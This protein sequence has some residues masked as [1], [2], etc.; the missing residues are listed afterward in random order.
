MVNVLS[1]LSVLAFS[2]S[3]VNAGA[4]EHAHA[5]RHHARGDAVMRR[6]PFGKD[7]SSNLT[8]FEIR[9]KRGTGLNARRCNAPDTTTTTTTSTSSTSTSTS[10]ST[11]PV[12]DNKQKLKHQNDQ[13]YQAP[14]T[15]TTTTPDNT[16][17]TT[18]QPKPTTSSGG[19]GGGGGGGSGT[20]SGDGTFYNT[21]SNACGGFDHDSDY[22][23]AVAH[24]MF[25]SYPGATG[26]PNNNPICGK[27]ITAHYQGKSVTC[28]VTDRCGGCNGGSLDFSPSAFQ[29]LASEDLGRISITWD[30]D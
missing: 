17:T 18:H 2:F 19:G 11:P 29:Q 27:M 9:K 4:H 6:V 21:G 3:A 14:T 22:I 20:Y 26:N 15:T 23:V 5:P 12:N 8:P 10:S 30:Y 25:D 7:T 24:G 16:P 1:V 13:P 28:K